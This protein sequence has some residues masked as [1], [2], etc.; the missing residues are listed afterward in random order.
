MAHSAATYQRAPRTISVQ[1]TMCRDVPEQPL[2]RRYQQPVLR[3]IDSDRVKA[4]VR[5]AHGESHGL[6]QEPRWDQD[7]DK[8][9]D[10]EEDRSTHCPMGNAPFV[11]TCAC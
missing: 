1:L 4:K 3:K 8:S 11:E 10:T 2:S 9:S 6:D 7:G 5:Y